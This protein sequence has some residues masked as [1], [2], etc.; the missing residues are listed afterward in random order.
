MTSITLT[1][2]SD[3]KAETLGWALIKLTIGWFGFMSSW[4]Y[5]LFCSKMLQLVLAS[6]VSG[7][8]FVLNANLQMLTSLTKMVNIILKHWRVSIASSSVSV[9]RL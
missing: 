4:R 3:I 1:P 5:R 9:Y 2:L 6:K 8:A 7:S